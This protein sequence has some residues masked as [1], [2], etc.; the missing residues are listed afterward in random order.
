MLADV[1]SYPGLS[2]P[3]LAAIGGGRF[4]LAGR[5]ADGAVEL[6]S[7]AFDGSALDYLDRTHVDALDSELAIAGR[8]DGTAL[9]AAQLERS[10]RPTGWLQVFHVG[11][12]G[13]FSSVASSTFDSRRRPVDAATLDDGSFAVTFEDGHHNRV[14]YVD[15]AASWLDER[16]LGPASVGWTLRGRTRGTSSAKADWPSSTNRPGCRCGT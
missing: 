10:R 12:S 1:D 7:W 13:R 14:A 6:T 8:D 11:Q 15:D 9:L 2:S 4:V 5:R 16:S 3:R